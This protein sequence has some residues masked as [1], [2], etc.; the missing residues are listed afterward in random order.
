MTRTH[1]PTIIARRIQLRPGTC[2]PVS[3]I[4][5]PVPQRSSGQE[6][7]AQ[8]PVSRPAG[9]VTLES[10]EESHGQYSGEASAAR[11]PG[12]GRRTGWPSGGSGAKSGLGGSV[13]QRGRRGDRLGAG[14]Q[15]VDLVVVVEDRHPGLGGEVRRRRAGGKDDRRDDRRHGSGRLVP[16]RCLPGLGSA[17]WVSAGSARAAVSASAS[18]SACGPP[19]P[20]SISGWGTVGVRGVGRTAGT[21]TW[22]PVRSP[23]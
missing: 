5:S 9:G 11:E 20:G 2:S 22:V 12:R 10:R 7:D 23:T 13:V 6:L 18:G 15:P 4:P 1:T 14:A 8:E 16:L 19:V 17:R 21:A 3:S